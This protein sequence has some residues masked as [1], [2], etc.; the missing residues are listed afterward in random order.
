MAT[1][2]IEPDILKGVTQLQAEGFQSAGLAVEKRSGI[3]DGDRTVSRV[4]SMGR[5]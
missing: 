2:I 1:E 4:G 5:D 3:E